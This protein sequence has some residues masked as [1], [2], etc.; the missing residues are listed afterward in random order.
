MISLAKNDPLYK[1]AVAQYNNQASKK[2]AEMM[3]AKFRSDEQR[4]KTELKDDKVRKNLD[5]LFEN[6]FLMTLNGYNYQTNEKL[7]K[8]SSFTFTYITPMQVLKT[9]INT[10]LSEGIR[11]L[12]NDIVVEGFFNNPAYKTEFSNCVFSSLEIADNIK[13]FEDS[14]NS[15]QRNDLST[16]DS[17]LKNGHKDQ[18]FMTKLEMMI[19][20]INLEASKIITKET[21]TLNA[22]FKIIQLMI[23]DSKKPTSETISN[24]KVLMMS[25]RNRDNTDLLEKQHANWEIFFEI[26]KNYA[27]ITNAK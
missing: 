18:E 23:Q 7:Q 5:K 15:G 12:L 3:R 10:Y 6:T 2:F 4:I 20:S 24:L 26:M 19:N 13:E 25:S 27:I 16:L 8:E 1:P 14:F 21:N 17:H 9:F 22:L 11:A